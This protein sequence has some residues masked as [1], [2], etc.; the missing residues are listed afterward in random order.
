MGKGVIEDSGQAKKDLFVTLVLVTQGALVMER[1]MGQ[2][3][4]KKW[5]K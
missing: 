3:V 1:T 4:I 5:A 2:L